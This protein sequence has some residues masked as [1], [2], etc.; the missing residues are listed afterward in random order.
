MLKQGTEHR[1]AALERAAV[2]PGRLRQVIELIKGFVGHRV[3]LQIAPDVLRRIQLRRIGRQEL[4][5]PGLSLGYIVLDQ[6]GPMGQEPVPYQDHRT[7]DM[8]AEMLQESADRVGVDIGLG[9]KTE[10]KLD[11]VAAW[12]DGQGG[13]RRNFPIGVGPMPQERRL[14]PGSPSPPHQGHHQ[15]AALVE[16]DKSGAYARGVFF[17]RGQSVLTQDRMASSSRSTARR[18]GFW[19]LQPS[20]CRTRPIWS[21]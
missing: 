16:K 12:R 10:E 5:A 15:E 8:S 14:T 7:L 13:D 1:F 20:A 9:M 21:T 4:R 11:T 17:T 2:T 3:G 6:T 18:C 19:G